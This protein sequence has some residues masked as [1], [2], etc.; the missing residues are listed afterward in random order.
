[1]DCL[2]CQI[3]AKEA[4][5]KIIY[6][7]AETMAFQNIRP[8][9]PIHLLIIPKK[10]ISSISQVLPEERDLIGQVILTAQKAAQ[11][12]GLEERG[13]KLAVNVGRGGGQEIFH[14]HFHLLGG[15]SNLKE[16]D[17]PGMP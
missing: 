6:E 14:L 2:F 11:L 9:A 5:A 8:L 13:Y 1:M 7:D 16:R 10:H 4:K 12:V 3:A 17:V 15:W